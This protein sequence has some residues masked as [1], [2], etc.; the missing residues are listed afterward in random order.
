[1]L[2]GPYYYMFFNY[3]RPFKRQW[4]AALSIYQFVLCSEAQTL[5]PLSN[6]TG[7][8]I[9]TPFKISVEADADIIAAMRREP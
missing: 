2:C 9:P 3:L 1:M 7:W 6:W 4:I 5:T 8:L